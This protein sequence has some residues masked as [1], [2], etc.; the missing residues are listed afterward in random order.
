M[1]TKRRLA[2]DYL[3][4]SSLTDFWTIVAEAKILESDYEALE[5]RFIAGYSVEQ[6]ALELHMSPEKVNRIIRQTYDKI[7]RL[8]T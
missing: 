8:I 2:R 6:I 3:N 4:D 1:N 7:A 5:K